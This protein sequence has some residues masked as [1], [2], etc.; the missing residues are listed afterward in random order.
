VFANTEIGTGCFVANS[1]ISWKC[2]V[3]GWTHVEKMT[4]IAEE[5]KVEENVRL[6]NCSVISFTSVSTN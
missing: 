2:K 6:E 5:V 3:G 1:V 4:C